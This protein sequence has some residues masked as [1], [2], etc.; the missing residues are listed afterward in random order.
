MRRIPAD[1]IEVLFQ[2]FKVETYDQ[3]GSKNG[4]VESLSILDALMNAGPAATADLVK[5][6]TKRWLTWKDMLLMK[7]VGVAG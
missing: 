3:I 6:G 4:F 7:K 2:D 1:D 5:G